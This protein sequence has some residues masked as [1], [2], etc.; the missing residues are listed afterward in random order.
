MKPFHEEEYK[1]WD[2]EFYNALN[3]AEMGE[4]ADIKRLT[5]ETEP[6]VKDVALKAKEFKFDSFCIK[7]RIEIHKDYNVDDFGI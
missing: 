5:S 3:V 2:I 4:H 1:W 7:E 6:V